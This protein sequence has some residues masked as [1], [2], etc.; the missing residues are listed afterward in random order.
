MEEKLLIKFN[1]DWAD[2][3]DVSGFMVISFKDWQNHIT[4]VAK[5]FLSTS[6]IEVY[7]GTN[8]SMTYESLLNYINKF[9][10]TPINSEE[11]LVLKKLFGVKL[12][13]NDNE[14]I[15]FGNLCMIEELLDEDDESSDEDVN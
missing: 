5:Q 9:T 7:F 6:E 14:Y 10:I 11:F 15:S 12:D 3:F 8:E 4:N 2:E 1:S 13:H